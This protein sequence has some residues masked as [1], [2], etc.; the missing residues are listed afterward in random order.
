MPPRLEL[1][2]P[3]ATPMFPIDG[4][5]DLAWTGGGSM[6]LAWLMVNNEAGHGGAIWCLM[7]NDGS[8]TIPAQDI[9]QLPSGVGPLYVESVEYDEMQVDGRGIGFTAGTMVS[10]IGNK[11]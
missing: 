6:T 7:E 2:E 10:L 8:F 1:H 3:S 5:L 4:A 9:A 11:P